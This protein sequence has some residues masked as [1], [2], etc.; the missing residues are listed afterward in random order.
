MQVSV[1]RVMWTVLADVEGLDRAGMFEERLKAHC[2]EVERVR[3]RG[4]SE[5][6][7]RVIQGRIILDL[8]GPEDLKAL[9]R[10]METL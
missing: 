7:S 2:G 8:T 4:R 9:R 3:R 10:E 1:G 5:G 6:F